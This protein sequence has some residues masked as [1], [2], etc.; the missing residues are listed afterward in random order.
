[1]EHSYA[2]YLRKEMFVVQNCILFDTTNDTNRK[3]ISRKA[4]V[5]V[6]RALTAYWPRAIGNE[7]KTIDEAGVAFL[8]FA[9]GKNA[10][11]LFDQE[12]SLYVGQENKCFRD[13]FE[14][15]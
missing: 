4:S 8:Q 1:M 13:A 12:R 15:N 10:K 11:R 6:R 7:S 14:C 3:S 9:R 5:L 2:G